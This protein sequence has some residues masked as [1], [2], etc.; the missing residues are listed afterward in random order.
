[1]V[2]VAVAVL[3]RL[4]VMVTLQVCEPLPVRTPLVWV[5][6]VLLVED[7]PEDTAVLALFST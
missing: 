4:S 6:L 1:M 7:D 2:L 5:A 3:P